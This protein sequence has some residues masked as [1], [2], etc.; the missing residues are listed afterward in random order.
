M[1]S[2]FIH[3]QPVRLFD[4]DINNHVNNS[5]YFT[6]MEEARTKLLFDQYLQC[7][8]NGIHFVVAEATCKYKMP[9]KIE[10]EVIIEIDIQKIR[11]ASFEIIY[12]FKNLKGDIFAVGKTQMA[13]FD[14]KAQRPVRIPEDIIKTIV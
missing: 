8:E 13:C 4:L 2:K 12:T 11:G 5:V 14:D 3:H 9:I 1:K 6:Y 7:K 10:D